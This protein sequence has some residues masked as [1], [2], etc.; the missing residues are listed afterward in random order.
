MIS[1]EYTWYNYA[2][3]TEINTSKYLL[4][5]AKQDRYTPFEQSVSPTDCSIRVYR[6]ILFKQTYVCSTKPFMFYISIPGI[7][8]T[9]KDTN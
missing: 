2:K 8:L 9:E 4:Y 6:S 3:K 1:Y 5:F 7:K